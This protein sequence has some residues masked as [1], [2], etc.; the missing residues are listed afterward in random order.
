MFL[1]QNLTNFIILGQ[2]YDVETDL[3]TKKPGSVG[4]SIWIDGQQINFADFPI[5]LERRAIELE[6]QSGEAFTYLNSIKSCIDQDICERDIALPVL[7]GGI[8][9]F[10][11]FEKTLSHG[12]ATFNALE[13]IYL[14]SDPRSY[15]ARPSIIGATIQIELNFHNMLC[16]E[17]AAREYGF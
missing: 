4:P 10:H 3:N 6:N 5:Q 2:M 1:F 15:A 7:C 17:K 14:H 8:N 11:E 12:S 16:P 9:E 13:D